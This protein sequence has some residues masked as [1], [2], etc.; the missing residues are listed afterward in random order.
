MKKASSL[1]LFGLSILFITTGTHAQAP[2]VT[3]ANHYPG[4]YETGNY[5]ANDIKESPYGGYVIAGSRRM[6]WKG[7]GHHE[8]MVMRVDEEGG[9][10]RMSETFTGYTID[11]ILRDG[12]QVLDTIPWDQ[13]VYDMIFTPVP[14]ISYLV[15]GFRDKTLH[16]PATPPGLF[17]MEVLG[18]GRV[19]FDSLYFNS[20][21]HHITGRC[22]QHAIGD[23]Y[24]IAGSIREDGGGTDKTLV[25]RLVKNGEGA[26]V[27]QETPV[28]TIIPVGMNG[29]ASWIRQFGGGYLLGGSAYNTPNSKYD[30][31]IQKIDEDL[32]EEWTLFYGMEDNDEFADGLLSGDHVY[33][34]G[35][36]KVPLPGTSYYLNQIYVVKTD[37]TGEV[38]WEK[39]FGGPTRHFANKIIITG[40]G[41]LLVAGTAYDQSMRPGIVLLNIDP[42]TGDSLW[43]QSYGD[44][45]S[46]GIRDAIRTSD[47]GYVM[48]GRASSTSV[49]DPRVYVMQLKNGPEREGL[50]LPREDVNLEIVTGTPA[51]D[52][53]DVSVDQANLYGISVRIDSLLHPSVGDLELTLEHAGTTVTL[54]D[55]PVHSGE[56][57]IRTILTDAAEMPLESGFAPYTGWYR[58]EETL[59]PFLSHHPA[60]VWT[61]TVTD[62]GVGG[63]KSTR[64]LAGWSLNLLVDSGSGTGLHDSEALPEFGL[65][66][67]RPNPV[68]GEAHITFRIHLPG[69]V[70]MTIYN[71]LGQLVGCLVNEHLSEGLHERIWSPGPLAPGTY[72]I[73]LE[74][75]GL[76]SVRKAI[77]GK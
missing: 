45:H 76:V 30:L 34:A 50:I 53:I 60:G 11:Y 42:E 75:G 48:A 14:H 39:T 37:S 26:Y 18:D 68:S 43:M 71:P 70:N 64:M 2:V 21:Q 61:L 74:S 59:L 51:V 5:T 8:V 44:F 52:V 6:T 20:N 40:E 7:L 31:F 57:F 55:Q 9:G 13:E 23:G 15:T 28:Y 33:L 1:L 24:I 10:I 66:Q 29:Y 4:G 72:F 46:A 65:E 56:N 36:A 17:L 47:F 54:V 32:N 63:K 69:Q 49:Q 3:W 77:L 22:I 19:K 16:T 35:S 41:S 58:P 67:V 27:H 73:H 12:E 38:V 25:T 62:H